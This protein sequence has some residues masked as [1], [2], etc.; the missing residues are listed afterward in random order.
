MPLVLGN[1]DEKFPYITCVQMLAA[2]LLIYVG[3]IVDKRLYL[4]CCCSVVHNLTSRV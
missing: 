4:L 3:G 2:A 1:P